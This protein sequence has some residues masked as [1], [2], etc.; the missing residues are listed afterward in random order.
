MINDVAEDLGDFISKKYALLSNLS[1][2]RS[3]PMDSA[4]RKAVKAIITPR[5]EVSLTF[6]LNEAE[7]L[8]KAL[9]DVVKLYGADPV[10]VLD[11]TL[12]QLEVTLADKKQQEV[13]KAEP[14]MSK[15]LA[16]FYER[17]SVSK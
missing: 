8:R 13:T 11:R 16:D 12:A 1:V 2:Y 4:E 6:N 7:K 5:K 10:F 3:G 14:P 15:D 17:L 9:I